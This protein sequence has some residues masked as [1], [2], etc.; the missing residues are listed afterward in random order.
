MIV[1]R[2]VASDEILIR[3]IVTPLFFDKKRNVLKHP[4]FLPPPNKNRCDVSLL[5]LRYTTD[6]FCKKHSK[7]LTIG[8]SIYWGL[9][10]FK[11]QHVEQINQANNF[12]YS[13]SV[14]ATPLD[15]NFKIVPEDTIVTVSDPGLPMHADMLYSAAMEGEIQS[16]MR[17]FAEELIL[18]AACYQ[19]TNP[20]SDEWTG[21]NLSNE[22]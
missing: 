17:K 8:T 20:E 7:T 10:G 5:R 9:A 21:P 11:P 12:S 15:E 18:L 14:L 22:S 1:P 19:D 4:A 3:G 16:E 6:T 2:V 13:V